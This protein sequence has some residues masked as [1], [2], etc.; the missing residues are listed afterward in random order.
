MKFL[1]ISKADETTEAGIPPSD[2]LIAAMGEFVEEGFKSGALLATDGLHPS[3]KAARISLVDGELTVTDGPF[4]AAKEVIASDALIQVKSKTE[5]IESVSKVLTIAGG[6][7]AEIYQVYEMDDF[8][9][10]EAIEHERQV[11]E[12]F[13]IK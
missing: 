1:C 3:S 5:A 2:E 4:A 13:G 9:P 10:S 6:G 7:N 11:R 8:A 12:E